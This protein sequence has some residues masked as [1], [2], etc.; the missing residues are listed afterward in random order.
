[1]RFLIITIGVLALIACKSDTKNVEKAAQQ[2]AVFYA[3]PI[4]SPH[5]FSE[6]LINGQKLTWGSKPINVALNQNALDTIFF[7]EEGLKWDTIICKIQSADSI[8]F[9]YND[10]CGGFNVIN[11][12]LKKTIDVNIT[13]DI[14]S[15]SDKHYLGICTG[16]SV[17]AKFNLKDTLKH[18]CPLSAMSPNVEQI[19]LSE[20]KPVNKATKGAISTDCFYTHDK[21]IDGMFHY[22][23]IKTITSFAYIPLQDEV[24]KVSY[25]PKTGKTTVKI[26]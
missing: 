15:F 21:R 25:N 20:I 9:R 8:F 13:F 23:T 19:E 7:R 24:L 10:C 14:A 3:D 5:G 4:Y 18:S 12:T 22:K 17:L 6:W 11:R 1:M 16:A 26:D 2:M